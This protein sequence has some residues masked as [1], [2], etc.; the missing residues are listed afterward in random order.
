MPNRNYRTAQRRKRRH[1]DRVQRRQEDA[2]Y[3]LAQIDVHTVDG[4]ARAPLD[5]LL[6]PPTPTSSPV[7]AP[8]PPAAEEEE[9]ATSMC[10]IV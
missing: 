10:V 3:T 6:E 8:V 1:R 4:Q 9:E 7:V 2:L 5:R